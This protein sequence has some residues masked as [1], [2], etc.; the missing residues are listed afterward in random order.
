MM[1][2]A[3]MVLITTKG[4]GDGA[5]FVA[6]VDILTILDGGPPEVLLGGTDVGVEQL[7]G[8]TPSVGANCAAR[9]S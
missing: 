6:P 9:A 2:I 3:T 8:V 1:K 7:P 4:C 5:V